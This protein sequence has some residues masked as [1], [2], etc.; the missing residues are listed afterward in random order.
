VDDRSALC[1]VAGSVLVLQA[2]DRS[3]R[4]DRPPPFDAWAEL[5]GDL[6]HLGARLGLSVRRSNEVAITAACFGMGLALMAT[7]FRGVRAV[8]QAVTSPG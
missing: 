4:I 8:A 7:G 6:L 1:A 2:L 3:T 5:R